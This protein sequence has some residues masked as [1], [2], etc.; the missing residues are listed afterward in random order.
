MSKETSRT[1]QEQGNYLCTFSFQEMEGRTREMEAWS[2]WGSLWETQVV[3]FRQLEGVLR[4]FRRWRDSFLIN[5]GALTPA[6]L[7][8]SPLL[9]LKASLCYLWALSSFP[10]NRNWGEG[11]RRW[12]EEGKEKMGSQKRCQLSVGLQGICRTGLWG[13][14][15]SLQGE[16]WILGWFFSHYSPT[17]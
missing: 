9:W 12:L 10:F 2:Q 5:E 6:P 17:C 4:D 11:A 13:K 15:K 1:Q 8:F 3:W 14:V 7:L 16:W